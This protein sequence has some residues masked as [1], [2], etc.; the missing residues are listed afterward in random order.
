MKKL[1]LVLI[2]VVL[3]AL[4]AC[5]R[6]ASNAPIP[7][8]TQ[9]GD[10]PFPVPSTQN[11]MQVIMTQTAQAKGGIGV[12]ATPIVI[13][14][15]T[16]GSVVLPT[17]TPELAQPTQAPAP[18]QAPTQPPAPA[19]VWQPTPGLPATYVLQNGEFPYCIARRFNL[20]AGELLSLNG[21]SMDSK[22]AEGTTLKIPT[23]GK[24]WAVGSRS[25]ASHPTSYTVT[26]GDSVY[27]IACSFGDVDPN[28]IIAVNNLQS[29]YTL[30]P[31]QTLQIP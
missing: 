4:T 5:T 15:A 26:S 9:A 11:P 20:D 17:S 30:T 21:L 12:D 18:T 8:A 10:L 28:G 7:T 6:S 13:P 22:P 27:S 31:G 16:T 1:S 29:P 24:P 2:V 19:V 14:T 3:L 23:S 25:L